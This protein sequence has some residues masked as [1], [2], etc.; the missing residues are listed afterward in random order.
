VIAENGW[1]TYRRLR[2]CSG[3]SS[4]L[5]DVALHFDETLR[6]KSAKLGA[7]RAKEEGT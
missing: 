2:T 5:S 3:L 4:V 6:T 1:E 7:R